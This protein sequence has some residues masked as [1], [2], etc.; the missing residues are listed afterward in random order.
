MDLLHQQASLNLKAYDYGVIIEY[1]PSDS[2][3]Y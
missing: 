2:N 3:N 1:F